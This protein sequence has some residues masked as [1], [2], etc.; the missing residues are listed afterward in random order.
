[1]I[2]SS[3]CNRCGT[4]VIEYGCPKGKIL[5]LT[6]DE[7][8]MQAQ[9]CSHCN[10]LLCPE[11][12]G[13]KSGVGISVGGARGACPVCKHGVGLATV[14]QM[15]APMSTQLKQP[16]KQKNSLAKLFSGP[17]PI[18]GAYAYM[19]I[20]T[21]FEPDSDQAGKQYI[22]EICDRCAPDLKSDVHRAAKMGAEFGTSL[23]D[24]GQIIH[25]ASKV[26]NE[27]YKAMS[28]KYDVSFKRF[29][30]PTGNGIVLIARHR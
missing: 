12:A 9:W 19:F 11:C 4:R 14:E 27:E 25:K 29:E 7:S 23:V 6:V 15:S 22:A 8:K 24:R 10:G 16:P 26:F 17:S 1:M 30:H 5:V 20:V 18:A 28:T 13:I 3:V 2:T 21:A